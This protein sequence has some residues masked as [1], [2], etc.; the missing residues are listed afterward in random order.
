[1][2]ITDIT[3]VVN[4]KGWRTVLLAKKYSPDILVGLGIIGVVSASVLTARATLKLEPILDKARETLNDL[5]KIPARNDGSDEKQHRKAVVKIYAGT[6]FSVAKIYAP[7]VLVEG[8]AVA[9][10]LGSHGIMKER[11][12]AL[13]VAYVTVDTAYRTYRKRVAD[14]YGEEV[15][16]DFHRGAHNDT[17]KEEGEDGKVKKVPVKIID[18]IGHSPHA[19][20]FDEYSNQWQKDPEYNLLFLNGQQNFMNDMLR[21]RG[22]VFLNEVYDR[23]GIPRTTEG[24]IMGWYYKP[25]ES[26]PI[27]FG[28]YDSNHARVREF[29][30]GYETSI[31]LDFNI[32]GV[33]YDLI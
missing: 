8:L 23:L 33:I 4:R 6:S 2:K 24:A 16:R 3:N 25:G 11:N 19:K 13:G 14:R 30:N 12:A 17:V 32:D 26:N 20:F 21:V 5:G 29:V 28:I 9:A 27:D 10:L 7:A 22:H 15:D 18:P 1:M 31:L